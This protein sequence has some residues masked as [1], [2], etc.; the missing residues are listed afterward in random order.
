MVNWESKADRGN[1]PP[2]KRR[3]QRGQK[4]TRPAPLM[5]KTPPHDPPP[6]PTAPRGSPI[7]KRLA[8]NALQP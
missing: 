8:K 5:D 7:A 3:G 2:Y 6:A 4:D 1:R